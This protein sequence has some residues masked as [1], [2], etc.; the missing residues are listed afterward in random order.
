ME[1]HYRSAMCIN[2]NIYLLT[3]P[4]RDHKEFAA[5]QQELVDQASW[6]IE[7][8]SIKTLE[9]RFARADTVIYLHF[10]RLLCA[11]RVFKRV[12]TI[13]QNLSNS[14]CANI[15]NWTLLK[16]IWNFKKEKSAR[17]IELKNQYP[18][19]VFREFQSSREL[20]NFLLDVTEKGL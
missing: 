9:M 4:K 18:D 15:V 20:E 6:I 11:W 19:L 8:C 2:C 17:I 13:D 5:I 14:G 12:F 1:L 10:P 16:Y 3:T 7:G